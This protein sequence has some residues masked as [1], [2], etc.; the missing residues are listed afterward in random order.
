MTEITTLYCA[1]HPTVETMLELREQKLYE[2][3]LPDL[4]EALSG[5]SWA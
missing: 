2:Q 4:Q 5:G 1:N 3:A